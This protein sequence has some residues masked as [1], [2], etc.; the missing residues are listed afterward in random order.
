M[1]RAAVRR[2]IGEHLIALGVRVLGDELLKVPVEEEPDEEGPSY[3]V[4]LNERAMQMVQE[5][6]PHPRVSAP[7]ELPKPLVGSLIDRAQ[8][9]R[10]L[11]R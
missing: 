5:G 8:R 2:W 10:A 7:R 1:I 9:Q 3:P 4:R 11:R 6:C